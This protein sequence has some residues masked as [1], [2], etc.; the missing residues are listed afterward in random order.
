MAAMSVSFKS[1]YLTLKFQQFLLNYAIKIKKVS[2]ELK[3]LIT[4][5]RVYVDSFHNLKFTIH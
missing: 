5:R 1:N 2:L 3:T 4:F